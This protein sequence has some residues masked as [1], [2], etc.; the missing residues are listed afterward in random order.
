MHAYLKIMNICQVSIVTLFKLVFL[1]VQMGD[2]D[3]KTF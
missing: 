3:L 2:V 1:K